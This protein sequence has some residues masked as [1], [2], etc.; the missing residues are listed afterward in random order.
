MG[1][2]RGEEE[3]CTVA[4]LPR[5]G[6]PVPLLSSPPPRHAPPVRINHANTNKELHQQNRQIS[7]LAPTA[8]GRTSN[9]FKVT[10]RFHLLSWIS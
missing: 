5:E 3:K 7:E 10:M 6:L 4:K 8:S 2:A 1:G 9:F